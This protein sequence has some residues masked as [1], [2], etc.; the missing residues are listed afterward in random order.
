M[1]KLQEGCWYG[2][3]NKRGH[4]V[5][6]RRKTENL[7]VLSGLHLK[8]LAE[9]YHRLVV[10]RA[11]GSLE[12]DGL[13]LQVFHLFDIRGRRDR[14]LGDQRL[15][16]DK[17]DLG[18]LQHRG[19]TATRNRHVVYLLGN[20]RSYERAPLRSYKLGGKALVFKH[21]FLVSDIGREMKAG[22]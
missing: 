3:C 12:A 6:L 17:N 22:G 19:G 10:S 11:A 14:P 21:A 9:R 16:D 4:A 15:T 8:K 5:R 20:T 7:V 1:R 13:T 2:P 18:A